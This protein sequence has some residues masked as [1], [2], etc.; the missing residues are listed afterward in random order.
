MR[1][2]FFIL[3]LVFLSSCKTS[4]NELTF[5]PEDNNALY[6]SVE[7][8]DEK[9]CQKHCE[10]EPAHKCRGSIAVQQN[11]N[12]QTLMCY[13]DDGLGQGT[14][15][16]STKPSMIKLRSVNSDLNNHRKNLGLSTVRHNSKL[17][18]AAELYAKY[19]AT[20]DD[21]T[22]TYENGDSYTSAIYDQGYFFD[23]VTLSVAGGQKTWSAAFEQMKNDKSTKG[24]LELTS[25]SEFGAAQYYAPSSPLQS[26]WVLFLANPAN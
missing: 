7:V 15:F 20:Q 12:D 19:L 9:E 22:S 10:S 1:K 13:M 3:P 21:L 23:V 4:P 26:Y 6:K 11:I 25:V 24:G 14:E 5:F 17:T 8:I 2:L 16:P 18:T